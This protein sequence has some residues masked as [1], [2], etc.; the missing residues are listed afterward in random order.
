MASCVTA[1]PAA[2]GAAGHTARAYP[3]LGFSDRLGCALKVTF[4]EKGLSLE[5]PFFQT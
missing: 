3:L 4:L 1:S 5:D 2:G